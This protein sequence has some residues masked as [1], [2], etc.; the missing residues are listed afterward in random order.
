MIKII[1]KNLFPMIIIFL[2]ILII[3]YCYLL[4]YIKYYLFYGFIIFDG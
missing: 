1:K 4:F 2:L 3:H